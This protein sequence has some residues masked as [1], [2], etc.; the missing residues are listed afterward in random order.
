ML[1]QLRLLGVSIHFERSWL[2]TL[3][4]VTLLVARAAHAIS[5]HDLSAMSAIGIGFAVG[6]ALTLSLLVHELAHARVSLNAG[7][8]VEYI[9]LHASGA[10]CRR[11]EPIVQARDQFS[12]AAAGPIA[13][14]ALGVVTLVAAFIFE[15]AA[16]PEALTAALWFVAFSNVL[17]AA[18][19]MLPLFPF[20]GGKALH[21]VFWR[22]SGDR[23]AA[24]DRVRRGGRQFSR[25]IVGF[26]IL[27]VGWAGE[28]LLGL[29]IAV[30]GIYLMFLRAVD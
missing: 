13:S 30:F 3:A 1:F 17:I 22:A 6:V 12:V 8:P 26:G 14:V 4:I 27:M 16:F 20:D 19:N 25:I 7:I 29:A 28:A 23:K 21:A 9:R 11:A 10:L 2:L 15:I 18:S 24:R 5:V